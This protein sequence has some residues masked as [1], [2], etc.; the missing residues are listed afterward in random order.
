MTVKSINWLMP[1]TTSKNRS[2]YISIYTYIVVHKNVPV[3]FRFMYMMQNMT[4][5]KQMLVLQH[6]LCPELNDKH[7]LSLVKES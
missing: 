3:Y 6:P 2:I 1:Q 4:R 5:K 7:V